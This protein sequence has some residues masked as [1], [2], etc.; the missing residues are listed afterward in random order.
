MFI[1]DFYEIAKGVEQEFGID[2]HLN[3]I[4][5]EELNTYFNYK[6]DYENDVITLN[7][8]VD[9]GTASLDI[10]DAQSPDYSYRMNNVLS[11]YIEE[12]GVHY[13]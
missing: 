3:V 10:V 1:T 13:C 7:F 2:M 6:Y 4:F 5:S 12:S 11:R 9:D 8:E